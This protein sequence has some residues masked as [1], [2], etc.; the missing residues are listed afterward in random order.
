MTSAYSIIIIGEMI[1]E[2]I[3]FKKGFVLISIIALLLIVGV[4]GMLF[5]NKTESDRLPN[6]GF[7]PINNYSYYAF[8]SG[9]E[10]YVNLDV[11][12]VNNHF[13]TNPD[14]IKKYNDFKLISTENNVEVDF[15][16]TDDDISFFQNNEF[17]F[18][19]SVEN[20]FEKTI[21]VDLVNINGNLN[22]INFNQLKY[23]NS[24]GI[25]ETKDFGSIL[26]D[27][28]VKNDD[29]IGALSSRLEWVKY[30]QPT[31]DQVE[32]VFSNNTATDIKLT[33]LYLGE[34]G[35]VPAISYPITLD[36]NKDTIV[37]YDVSLKKD[38]I[39]EPMYYVL[40]PRYE[41]EISSEK[42]T[43]V[44]SNI[45]IEKYL[46]TDININEYLYNKYK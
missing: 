6:D 23:K 35:V 41:F 17:L 15:K 19:D 43:G 31:F 10:T 40:K 27:L 37:T 13:S 11:F 14:V 29:E 2:N 1:M 28:N 4:I 25:Y 5:F 7:Y 44:F 33:G 3:K 46:S 24:K 34:T 39:D 21:R 8:A 12:F 18:S 20:I 38:K 32:Y 22:Q 26:V 42:K 16:L 36:P 30:E 9:E 45:E